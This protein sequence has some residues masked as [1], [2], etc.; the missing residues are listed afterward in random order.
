M[1]HPT[2]RPDSIREDIARHV[3]QFRER[4][5]RFNDARESYFKQTFAR[6]RADL[7]RTGPHPSTSA[8]E[9]P[10]ADAGLPRA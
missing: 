2:R 3:A 4:Q 7:D 9:T 10:P 8:R 6:L 5:R 1:S